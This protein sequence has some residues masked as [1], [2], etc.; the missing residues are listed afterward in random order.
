MKSHLQS[1]PLPSYDCQ[2]NEEMQYTKNEFTIIRISSLWSKLTEAIHTMEIYTRLYKKLTR[3][4][5]NLEAHLAKGTESG[6]STAAGFMDLH[7]DSLG[8]DST[9]AYLIALAQ[10]YEMNGDR[11]S[12]PDMQVRIN[13]EQKT[14]EA[15]TFQNMYLYQQ[16]YEEAEGKHYVNATLKKQ[17]NDFLDIWLSNAINQ[18]HRIV[19]PKIDEQETE[20]LNEVMNQRTKGDENS[21]RRDR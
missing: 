10:Y 14:A 20:R 2:S 7:F 11:V 18:N 21:Q 6:T 9:G 13:T 19:L 16:V 4:I 1:I 8:K 12:D 17:L 3:L 5:P 15:L